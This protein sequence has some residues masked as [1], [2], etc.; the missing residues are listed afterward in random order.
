MNACC[1]EHAIVMRPLLRVG[2]WSVAPGGTAARLPQNMESGVSAV[3][4]PIHVS[5][6]SLP[7]RAIVAL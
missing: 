3:I 1:S 7:D 6:F 2:R 4:H 5:T